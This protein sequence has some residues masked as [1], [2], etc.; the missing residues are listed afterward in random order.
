MSST[1]TATPQIDERARAIALLE[2]NHSFPTDYALSVIARNAEE[3]AERVLAAAFE[4][5]E[6]ARPEGAHQTLPS[7]GGKYISHR[8]TIRCQDA[9]QVLRVYARLRAIEGVL[10]IL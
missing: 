2:S 9:E 4:D 3:V 10:T 7:S 6:A 8:L 5:L 1:T